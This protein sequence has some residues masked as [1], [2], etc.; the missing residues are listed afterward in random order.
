MLLAFFM[1]DAEKHKMYRGVVKEEYF[2]I[3]LEHFFLFVHKKHML[4]VHI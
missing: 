2:V 4:R 1:N 3:I